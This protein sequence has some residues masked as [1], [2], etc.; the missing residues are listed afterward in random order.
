MLIPASWRNEMDQ[1]QKL[2]NSGTEHSSGERAESPRPAQDTGL[3]PC[4]YCGHAAAWVEDS[5]QKVKYGNDQAYCPNC[6][7]TTT[8]AYGKKSAAV[9]WNSR[10][11][12]PNTEA[13]RGLIA[14]IEADMEILRRISTQRD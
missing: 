14:A 9:W 13:S 11:D 5:E 2:V 3:L 8:P 6:Y 7:A 12:D 1:N 4:P 10:A